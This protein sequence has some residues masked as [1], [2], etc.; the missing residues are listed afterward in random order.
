MLLSCF[1]V[2]EAAEPIVR[3]D[4][5]GGLDGWAAMG[6]T[7]NVR[8]S[9]D[10]GDMRNGKPSL[11]LDYE[12]G[13][14]KFAIASLPVT[15]DKLRGM[16]QVHFWVRTE[17]GTSVVV[18]LSEKGGGNYSAMAW[19]PGG[20]WQEV[21]VELK[22]FA[23]GDRASDPP[24]PDGRLDPEQVQGIGITDLAQLFGGAPPNAAVPIAID[25]HAGKHTLLV[26]EFEVLGGI[27][28][29]T[30]NLVIDSFN[31]PQLSWASP[32]GAALHLDTS[33]QH[34]PA[35]GME[36]DYAQDDRA[37][38]FVTRTLPP[39]IPENVTHIS[40]DIASEKPVE[41][42]FTLQ[43]KGYGLGEGPRY[44][45][46]VEV[47]GK[48]ISDHRNLALSAFH[49]DAN[50][51][52]DPKGLLNI[53]QAK[54]LIIADLSPVTDHALGDNRIWISNIRFVVLP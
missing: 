14:R 23:L 9:R 1:A 21:R 15:P 52:S 7:G 38:V 51:P 45:V 6:P 20:V 36:V 41:L 17:F 43:R 32:G 27:P 28:P 39:D 50:G 4:W 30:D 46:V 29:R 8:V 33:R 53:T 5:A 37:L 49:L 2:C 18:I 54:S 31:T 34:V 3:A 26:N 19:S 12:V 35:A 48:G 13:E 47:G 16:G 42:V 44:N 40:F 22:D 10:A 24:D 11:A 25:D